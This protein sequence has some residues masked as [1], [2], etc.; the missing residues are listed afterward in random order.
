MIL[1]RSISPSSPQLNST[2]ANS[3]FYLLTAVHGLH[4]LGGL[5]AWGRVV[6]RFH[7]GVDFAHA[8]MGIDLCTVYWH[9]LLV[10]WGVLFYLLL[11]T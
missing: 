11:S 4:I 8:R 2:P 7:P 9:Y 1:R 10:V 5:V 3:Y 6:G